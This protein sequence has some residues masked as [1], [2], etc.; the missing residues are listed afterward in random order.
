[1]DCIYIYR[2][3]HFLVHHNPFYEIEKLKRKL[4]KEFRNKIA[5]LTYGRNISCDAY[6]M[7]VSTKVTTYLK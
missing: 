1:M 4:N 2:I 5:Y 3:A 6:V 7:S